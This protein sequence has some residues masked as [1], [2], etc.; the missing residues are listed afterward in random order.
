MIAQTSPADD[1]AWEKQLAP[2]ITRG[3]VIFAAG[4][5]C[6]WLAFLATLAAIRWFGSLE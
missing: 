4:V 6:L 2:R 5:Y 1:Y 3:K